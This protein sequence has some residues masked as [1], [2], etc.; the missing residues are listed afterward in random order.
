MKT[1]I[2]AT[3]LA[4][5]I[6]GSAAAAMTQAEINDELRAIPHLYNGLFT[7][8][9]IKHVTDTCPAIAPPGRAARTS[10][11]LGLYNRA[12]GLGYTR[13]Q[14]R[15]FV[16]D[17][18]EQDRMRDLVEQ[19]LRRAGVSDPFSEAEICAYARNEISQA[20]ALGRQLRER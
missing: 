13:A 9:T 16:E 19:H 20:T 7:A 17:K 12:R 4:G 15:A 6:S 10:F 5:L 3:A 8:A 14:I 18:G 2:L 1:M 11:F